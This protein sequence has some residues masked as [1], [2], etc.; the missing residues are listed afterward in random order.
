M[1]AYHFLLLPLN[2]DL[3]M[4]VFKTRCFYISLLLLFRN[5]L[6]LLVL[7]VRIF[8]K[9]DKG[10]LVK[11]RE[12]R[13]CLNNLQMVLSCNLSYITFTD[14]LRESFEDGE[15]MADLFSLLLTR[16]LAKK[17]NEIVEDI[18]EEIRN[19]CISNSHIKSRLDFSRWELNDMAFDAITNV[20]KKELEIYFEDFKKTVAYRKL[21]RRL[22]HKE[23]ANE[24]L[25]YADLI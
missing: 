24:R 3:S 18:D 11:N 14:Y 22:I 4:N 12:T 16:K 8:G 19:F 1:A 6:W 5:F 20:V 13:E 7:E 21:R 25:Q 17:K 2:E 9:M 10:Y 15:A 23:L